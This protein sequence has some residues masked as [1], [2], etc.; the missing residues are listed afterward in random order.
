MHGKKKAW[1]RMQRAVSLAAACWMMVAAWCQADETTVPKLV[2]ERVQIAE[3]LARLTDV[4]PRVGTF[5]V[6]PQNWRDDVKPHVVYLQTPQPGTAVPRGS[7]V[8][9]WVFVRAAADAE[10]IEVPDFRGLPWDQALQN[11]RDSGLKLLTEPDAG[12][13]AERRV[14]DQ[15]PAAASRVYRGTSLLLTGDRLTPPPAPDAPPAPESTP[16][17]ATPPEAPPAEARP[18]EAPQP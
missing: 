11:A 13:S 9:A 8:A 18:P 1:T 3:Q 15:Y 10:T 6:A 4:R 7:L 2:G 16:P 12:E 5:Y 17:V 14:I